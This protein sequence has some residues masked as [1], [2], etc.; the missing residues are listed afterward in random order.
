MIAQDAQPPSLV[1]PF[2]ALEGKADPLQN[3]S[4][5]LI[6]YA[7]PRT[8]RL[9][10]QLAQVLNDLAANER[11]EMAS[12]EFDIDGHA[13]E[14]VD[15]RGA[16]DDVWL[17]RTEPDA[18]SA[19]FDSTGNKFHARLFQRAPDT[20]EGAR[21]GRALFIL[22]FPDRREGDPGGG[23]ELL[24]GPIEKA[25]GGSNLSG[26]KSLCRQPWRPEVNMKSIIHKLKNTVL[27]LGFMIKSKN[28]PGGSWLFVRE[29]TRERY[30]ELSGFFVGRF[31]APTLSGN[32]PGPWR[33]FLLYRSAPP[34]VG[35]ATV[36]TYNLVSQV[37][38]RSPSKAH[39]YLNLLNLNLSE[40]SI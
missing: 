33:I 37:R 21:L 29:K 2:V 5:V 22:D 24:L 31:L 11:F 9:F 28:R 13:V 26:N 8:L 36:Y 3:D 30:F 17:R 39:K 6:E 18:R 20:C 32:S 15:H 16:P 1:P 4:F 40:T 10:P 7:E 23:R 35:S 19:M 27:I 12:L 38:A 25:A 34:Q 14:E